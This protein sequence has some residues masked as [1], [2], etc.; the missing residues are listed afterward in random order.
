MIG[1]GDDARAGTQGTAD[2][3][4]E[5]PRPGPA[6]GPSPLPRRYPHA[7]PFSVI[8]VGSGNPWPSLD[9]AAACT[10]V[11][12][13]GRYVMLDA[14]N[15]AVNS[16]LRGA[17][18][19]FPCR[20]IA[21][22]CFT[23]FHQD[24]STDYF[25]V[26]TNRWL[27][28]GGPLTLVGP[29]G[30]GRLHEFLTDFYRDDL[31]YRWMREID[32]GLTSAG[33]FS[34]V[35]VR[36]VAG[37]DDFQLAGLHVTTAELTHT[38]YNV[39]YRF[40][41]GGKCIVV[42]GDTSFDERLVDLA[43]DADVLVMDADERWPGELGHPAPRPHALPEEYRPRG[44]HGGD[45][46]VR[47]HAGIEEVADMAAR[48]GVKHLVLTHLRPG[49]VDEEAVAAVYRDVGFGG[50]VTLARDGLEVDA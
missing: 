3:A 42:S 29:P 6:G 40:E 30:V 32:R 31:A 11:Q 25:D 17:H 24:H 15:G 4:A 35:E 2:L 33:M 19:E 7:A 46:T 9:R 44:R 27:T 38:Q 49:P 18:G 13:R 45:F 37:A 12:Y 41:A 47:A 22:V 36:E 43:R 14:G 39:G 26:A 21:A 20:D 48:A 50:A 34:E 5:G 23:H 8:T 10:L 1:V 16:L 28:G